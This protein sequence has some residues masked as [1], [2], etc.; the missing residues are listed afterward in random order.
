M[1]WTCR[2]VAPLVG[3]LVVGCAKGPKVVPELA[4]LP[5]DW[6]PFR[7]VDVLI[8]TTTVHRAA[9][10]VDVADRTVSGAVEPGFDNPMQLDFGFAGIGTSGVPLRLLE[11]ITT[12]SATMPRVLVGRLSRLGPREDSVGLGR[13]F[14]LGTLGLLFY[15]NRGLIIDQVGQRLGAPRAGAPLPA[16]VTDRMR[17]TEARERNGRLELPFLWRSTSLG[18]L[19]YDPGSS[20]VP[21][22]LEPEAWRQVTGRRGDEPD[23]LRLAFPTAGDSLILVGAKPAG[24][25][26]LGAIS[27]DDVAVY[28]AQSGPPALARPP[29]GA[30]VVG[31]VGNQLF[32]GYRLV[33]VSVRAGRLG[34]LR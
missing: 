31:V 11:P 18:N 10:L 16:S 1:S 25:L 21:V 28:F 30:G 9:M 29:L 20:L 22:V 13:V 32:Q 33:Y 15:G 34:V 24:P 4:T 19:V 6:E 17:W 7:W 27:F 23:N 26:V 3:L 14:R 5:V 8:G 2:W 12:D